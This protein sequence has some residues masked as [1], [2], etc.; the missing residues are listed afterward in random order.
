MMISASKLFFIILLLF[1]KS[2]EI[3]ALTFRFGYYQ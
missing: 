3:C 1:F 2:L